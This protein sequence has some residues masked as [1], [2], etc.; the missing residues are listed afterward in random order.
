M[1]DLT[2]FIDV[3]PGTKARIMG[4]LANGIDITPNFV[5]HYGHTVATFRAACKKFEQNGGE[6]VSFTFRERPKNPI[7]VVG[8]YSGK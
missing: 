5:D 2:D 8:K 1:L 3:H 6:A 4:K 7:R